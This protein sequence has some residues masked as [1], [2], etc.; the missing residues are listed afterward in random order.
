MKTVWSLRRV[1]QTCFALLLCV[2]LGSCSE[3][4][5]TRADIAR[6]EQQLVLPAGAAPLPAYGRHYAPPRLYSEE[7]L[8]FTTLVDSMPGWPEPRT[9]PVAVGVFV[10]RDMEGWTGAGVHLVEEEDLPYAFDGGCRVVN[11]IFDPESM[12]TMAVWCNWDH[13]PSE[14]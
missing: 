2:G 13:S 4:E 12:R 8:P 3:R 14:R 5:L 9:A 1:S 11:V 7:D 6:F 10:M